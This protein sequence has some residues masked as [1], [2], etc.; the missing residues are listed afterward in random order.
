MIEIILER[1]RLERSRIG[2][3][4]SRTCK[5]IQCEPVEL[6]LRNQN[7][8]ASDRVGE[9]IHGSYKESPID[10]Q[11]WGGLWHGLLGVRQRRGGSTRQNSRNRNEH[12]RQ[13]QHPPLPVRIGIG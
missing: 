11:G 9:T 3:N 6:G 12:Q 2:T 1:G 5:E 7:I 8:A 13:S 10:A 4:N